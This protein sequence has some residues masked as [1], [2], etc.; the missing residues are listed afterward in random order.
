MGGADA[1][2]HP[3]PWPVLGSYHRHHAQSP[4]IAR[5]SRSGGLSGGCR[6]GL[7]RP[8]NARGSAG[9]PERS[10]PRGCSFWPG[11]W[12]ARPRGCRPSSWAS[13]RA[14]WTDT[15]VRGGTGRPRGWRIRRPWGGD[16]GCHP[17]G[18]GHPGPGAPGQLEPV[19]A[20]R[21]GGRIGG[22]FDAPG[23]PGVRPLAGV[24]GTG[25]H[26]P[27]EPQPPVL[28]ERAGKPVSTS[29][30]TARAATTPST[31]RCRR[32]SSRRC[33]WLAPT[34]RSSGWC[35]TGP[36]RPSAVRRPGRVRALPVP[37]LPIS[38]RLTRSPARR[39]AELGPRLEVR[40]HGAC[41]GAG[42]PMA[43]FARRV[44]ASPDASICRPR[45][46]SA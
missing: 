10:A 28:V 12:R 40:L 5:L 41:I 36:A 33:W 16:G 4:L 14:G 44:V 22:V 18:R 39:L 37:P 24:H 26:R 6:R 42:I 7:R 30:S 27:P 32:A 2:P 13:G 35:W 19:R 21:L 9:R 43:A 34:R 31:P 1:G 8:G 25:A 15:P 20:G 45:L 3:P 46:A 23:Q 38:I 29:P 11:G 17:P